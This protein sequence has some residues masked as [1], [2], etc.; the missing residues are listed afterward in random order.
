MVD[1]QDHKVYLERVYVQQILQKRA[2][3]NS[4]MENKCWW[5]TTVEKMLIARELVE[6]LIVWQL[7]EGN[8]NIWLDSWTSQGDIYSLL[9]EIRDENGQYQQVRNIVREDSWDEQVIKNM[10]TEEMDEHILTKVKPPTDTDS[11]WPI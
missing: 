9:E 2:S 3:K 1:F 5:I 7:R 4:H 10:F 6:H 8:F 11:D